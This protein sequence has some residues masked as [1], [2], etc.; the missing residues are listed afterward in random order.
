MS[1]MGQQRHFGDC[2]LLPVLPLTADMWRSGGFR[3]R[4][5]LAE[6][7]LARGIVCTPVY[8]QCTGGLFL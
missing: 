2:R 1:E 3:R 5:P 6:V 8:T 7:E 4:G